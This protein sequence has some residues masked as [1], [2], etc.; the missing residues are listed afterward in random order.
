MSKTR[1]A[2]TCFWY[3]RCYSVSGARKCLSCR[4]SEPR[5]IWRNSLMANLDLSHYYLFNFEIVLN[6]WDKRLSPMDLSYFCRF[7]KQEL[8]PLSTSINCSWLFRKESQSIEKVTCRTLDRLSSHHMWRLT[9][10]N[11]R[12]LSVK[13]LPKCVTLVKS[14]APFLGTFCPFF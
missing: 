5:K 12:F 8:L 6:I 11:G 2:Q 9:F 1:C 14:Q 13:N 3:C 10:L 4:V 7:C